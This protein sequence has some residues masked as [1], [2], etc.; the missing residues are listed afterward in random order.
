M[1]YP[2]PRVWRFGAWLIVVAALVPLTGCADNPEVSDEAGLTLRLVIP[3]TN[4]REP[5]VPCSGASGF[6]FA[7]PQA[8]FI[9]EDADG[10]QV[11]SGTLPEGTAEK[12]FNIDLGDE[13]QPTVCVM[14]VEVQGVETLDDHYLV[15]DD[16]SPV[17]IK[18]NSSLEDIPEVVLR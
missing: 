10:R 8:P 15:I 2:R 3:D 7:H 17:P 6:R 18:P 1:S 12:A 13:R 4:I 9:V 14:M 11:A 5:D 16:R